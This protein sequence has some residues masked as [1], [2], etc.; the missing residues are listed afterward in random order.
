MTIPD[1]SNS[2]A[3]TTRTQPRKPRKP[4][5]PRSKLARL[6]VPNQP[7]A[8]VMA[9]TP[10]IA[11]TLAGGVSWRNIW[12]C[13]AWLGC[14]C[15]QFTMSRWLV[16]HGQ[17]RYRAPA[18]AY[19]A[20]TGVIGLPLLA[21]TPQ[22]LW[23]AL[24]FVPLA[25]ASFLLAWMRRDRT[26]LA[27]AVAAL[28]AGT[29]GAVALSLGSRH[30]PGPVAPREAVLLGMVFAA[31]EFGQILFVPSM[32]TRDGRR[33]TAYARASVAVSVLLAAGGFLLHPAL[34]CVALLLL[35]RAAAL[36][37]MVRRHWVP[38]LAAAP[39]ELATSL[40]VL[41]AAVI[42]VPTL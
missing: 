12:V 24:A 33:A 31:F 23:W 5:K 11:G 29:I 4:R 1:R 41:A 32:L 7:G 20:A 16:S 14:Y 25:A 10:A 39:C 9:M 28:A 13:V 8:W 37:A 42:A 2:P 36:P 38:P 27:Q 21:L 15:T 34:G 26:L 3:S 6:W 30:F 17:Q 40:A 18:L 19:A 35:A 22:L